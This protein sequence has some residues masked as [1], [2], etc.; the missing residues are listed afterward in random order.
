M[1]SNGQKGDVF[2][3]RSG[4]SWLHFGSTWM[5]GREVVGHQDPGA[6]GAG[7]Y[8]IGVEMARIKVSLAASIPKQ[9]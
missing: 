8:V 4:V 9:H 5:V 6:K 1:E 2:S 7:I 3:C